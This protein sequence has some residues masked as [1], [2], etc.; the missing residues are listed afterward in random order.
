MTQAIDLSSA[1]HYRWGGICDGW[2]LLKRSDLSI[3]AERVPP[4]GKESRHSH[5]RARQF[6]Y[7]L[8][9]C[10]VMEV[11][12]ERVELREGQGL[13]VAPGT[14]HQFLNESPA[15]VHFLVISHPT[16]RG[17]RNEH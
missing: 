8:S 11:D 10:A 2:H 9:G 16:T 17:D 4:G 12:G 5:E 6:F 15:V 3:I 14:P 1:E 7:I 13:E